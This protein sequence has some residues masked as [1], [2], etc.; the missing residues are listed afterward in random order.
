[1]A[2]SYSG[3]L[4]SAIERAWAAIDEDRLRDLALRMVSIPSPTGDERELA[5]FLT[6]YLAQ[7]GLDSWYQE[8]DDR[9]G[10]AVGR[11]AGD[12]TGKDLLLYAPID[13]LTVGTAEE[14]V[15]YVGPALRPDMRPVGFLD[16][17]RVVGLGASN[18]K[19]HAACAAVAAAAIAAAGLP[20]HGSLLVGFGAG[21]MPTNS[22][23]SVT[24]ANTGQGN[25]CSF[26]LEQGVQADHAILAKPGWFISWEE[27]GLCW[28]TVRVYGTYNYV[29]SRQR[30]PYRN[31]IVD[32]GRLIGELERWFPEYTA[33]NTSGLVAPQG[34]V[35]SI[36]GGWQRMAATSPA[37]C[38]FTVDLRISP[39]TRPVDARRQF[40]Q[41]IDEALA[42]LGDVSAEWEM[43][44]SIP[45]SS[46]PPETWIVD[47][48]R[49][50][51]AT[52]TGAPQVL[53]EAARTTSGA[54]DGNILRNRGIP[55]ARIGM[56]RVTNPDGTEVDFPM[57]MNAV[58]LPNMVKLTRLLVAA[59]VDACSRTRD[60]IETG[61]RGVV[62]R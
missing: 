12:D 22:R 30:L 39:R 58:S 26:M 23:N 34:H 50:A 17:D 15:P 32:A 43:T 27:V 35:A 62:A 37:V 7:A 55:T 20:L 11:L 36:R 6:G 49:R 19:G 48:C 31:A 46:T 21:G 38:E 5:Q 41:A 1:M 60:E 24:R 16:G 18:P 28:F 54:T 3:S 4:R 56:P 29:G 8:I 53:D 40:A 61:A 10:N 57:G 52:V 13:T 47:S 42:R 59:A 9:Q 25:G 14:D 45:G 33:R 51:Y 44:L 2:E